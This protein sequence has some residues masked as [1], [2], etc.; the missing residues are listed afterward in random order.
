MA[1]GS[2]AATTR[3][4]LFIRWP[5]TFVGSGSAVIRPYDA[6]TLDWEGEAAL[7]IGRRAR[8]V[9]ADRAAECIA[10]VTG[11]AEN[12]ERDWQQH[13]GQATA[14]KNWTASGACG[15]WIATTDELPEGPL[16]VTTRLNGEIVQD[17]TTDHLTYPFADLIS[18]ISTF[19]VL[20]PGDVIATGTPSGIGY[21]RIPPRF[22]KPG[23][24]MSV[25]VT[26]VGDLTY[27]V[28]DEVP[29]LA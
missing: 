3:P 11:M 21:R 12:S 16:R 26:G 2:H 28:A 27:T 9:P 29:A 18:Y 8:R 13:S 6:Q 24:E 10:G 22:L 25:S 19:T 4:T 7:V 17:D 5:D 20:R 23:D 15:P 1:E 14:G